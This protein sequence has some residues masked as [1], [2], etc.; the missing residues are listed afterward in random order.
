MQTDD[1][2]V[3]AHRHFSPLQESW[4]LSWYFI[5]GICVGKKGVFH[6]DI[7]ILPLHMKDRDTD[8]LLKHLPGGKY[9]LSSSY[10]SQVKQMK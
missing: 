3:R 2:K 6:S 5:G 7:I 10:C 8:S 1:S 4:G 9:I